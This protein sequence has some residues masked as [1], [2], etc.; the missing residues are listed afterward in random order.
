MMLVVN[1][2]HDIRMSIVILFLTFLSYHRLLTV[3]FGPSRAAGS[4][5]KTPV[6][7][8]DAGEYHNH[9]FTVHQ[10]DA[11]R[12]LQTNCSKF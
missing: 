2:H 6:L 11:L 8:M 4:A 10:T 3:W 12:R 7:Q 1:G 9:R 5:D